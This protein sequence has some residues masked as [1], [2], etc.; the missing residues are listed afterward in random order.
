MGKFRRTGYGSQG[1]TTGRENAT[2]ER[3]WFSPHCQHP[4]SSLPLFA[5]IE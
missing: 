1:E 2:R 5:G 3:L 4:D